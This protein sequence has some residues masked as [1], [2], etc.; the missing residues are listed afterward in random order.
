[1]MPFFRFSLVFL[2][3]FHFIIC[4]D[5]IMTLDASLIFTL[6]GGAEVCVNHLPKFC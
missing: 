1:M 5:L 3:P 2:L 6:E 4:H